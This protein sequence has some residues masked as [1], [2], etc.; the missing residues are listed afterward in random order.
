MDLQ[1]LTLAKPRVSAYQNMDV[2]PCRNAVIAAG[3]LLDPPKERQKQA[4]F[5]QFVTIDCRTECVNQMTK[6]GPFKLLHVMKV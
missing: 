2:S 3:I 5:D 6:L 1:Q 4:S